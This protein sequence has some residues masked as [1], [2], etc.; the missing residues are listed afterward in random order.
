[1]TL[2]DLEAR[3]EDTGAGDQAGATVA[4]GGPEIDPKPQTGRL[5]NHLP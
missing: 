2:T 1:M 5:G 3:G 4:R